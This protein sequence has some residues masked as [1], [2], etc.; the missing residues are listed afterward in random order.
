MKLVIGQKIKALRLSSD[1]TQEELANRASIS[2]GFVSQLEN[3]QT[4]IQIDTLADIV[5]ALGVTLVEFFSDEAQPTPVFR[6]ADRVSIDGT[7]AANYELLVPGSTN[8]EMDP[9]LVSLDPGEGLAKSDPHPGEQFGF[10]M[11]G[12]VT[13]Q[14]GKKNY[15]ARKN[16]CFSFRSE[17]EHQLRNENGTTALL[18]LVTTPPQM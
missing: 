1:L 15:K 11:K 4:S 2:K 9:V 14:L 7:G 18:L 5:E 8:H 12:T 16:D 17:Q 3:D 13:L 10:V 6:P